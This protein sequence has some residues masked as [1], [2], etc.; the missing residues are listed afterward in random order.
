MEA[1]A[2]EQG[3]VYQAARDLTVN[4]HY[5]PTPE[6]DQIIEGDI[7]QRP[8][9]FQPRPHLL[10]R[11]AGVL[12]DL[13]PGQSGD[14]DGGGNGGA[15]VICAVGGTPG[16]GKTILAAS[17]AWAC[18]AERWPVV[19]WIAAETTA[20]I[21]TGLASLAQRLGERRADDDAATAAARAKAWLA[22]TERPALLVFD[23]AADPETIR[24]WC[25]ATGATRVLIT[26]RNRA[27][28]RLFEPVEVEVFTPEQAEAFL[29]R[30]TGLDDPG[31]AEALADELGHLP[32]ALDQAAT[33]IARL[34][35]SYET[36]LILLRDFPVA[37][38]LSAQHGDPYPAGTAEVIL[39]SATQ[40]ETI[41]PE[42]T[43]LL[44][45]LAVLS[46]A[47]VPLPVLHALSAEGIERVRVQQLLADLTDTSLITFN[48]DGSAVLMHRLVQRVLR[49]R[50]AHQGHLNGV[51]SQAVN[52]LHAFNAALPDGAETWAAR[53]AVEMLIDQTNTLYLWTQTGDGLSADL[54]SLRHWCGQYLYD[55]ADLTRAIPLYEVTL[56]DRER[57]LGANHPNTLASRNNLASAYR[58]AGDLGRAIPLYE[59]T[60]AD[61]ERVLDTDHPSILASRNNLAGAYQAAGDLGRAIPLYGTTLADRE[62]VLGTDH[63]DTLSSR[64]NLAYAYQAAGDL[65]RAIPL[66]ET[67]LADSVR[68]LGAD[69]PDTLSSRNNLASA[70]ESAGDLGR[71]IPLYETTL[72]DREQ[73]LG[74][75]HPNTLDSR[76]NLAGAYQA[77]GDLGRAIPLHEVTLADSVRVLGT[78]HP[79][80]LSSRNNLANAYQ[81]AGDLGRAIPLYETTLADRERVM[82]GDHPDTLTSRNNLASAH[83][84][85]GD[86]GRA[87]L[88]YE[89]TLADSVRVLGT[90]HPTTQ[91]VRNNLE[92]ALQK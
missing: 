25:P 91:V 31:G 28:L 70:Y 40:A 65:G 73:V 30:R 32:L 88:L 55:L 17:Y 12:G 67:T 51:L 19:A 29:H 71:A 57:V 37:D 59:T 4:H 21:H 60:L 58:S 11:L 7:P 36:Y 72:A 16:V 53:A 56:A 42:A 3:R 9:S 83:Q 18:Q 90:N 2:S 82:G 86:L 45:L 8:P 20:Q 26:T 84:A 75:D 27:F 5:P 64:N 77:A 87:I 23:N 41:L 47:G 61:R 49:D 68:V 14:E 89:A 43:E 33:V 24:R 48:E 35:L 81:A 85:A 92:V 34:R 1:T 22:A 78:D 52:L 10:Q 38:Y 44:P 80:T 62:R 54:L 74:A 76:N 15:A 66:Y 39:L 69:H 63:P 50:A 6:P 79:N 13:A 46:P